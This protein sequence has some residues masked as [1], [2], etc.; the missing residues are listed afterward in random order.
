MARTE[1]RKRRPAVMARWIGEV[2]DT[3]VCGGSYL[4]LER[5][6]FFEPGLELRAIPSVVRVGLFGLARQLKIA[7]RSFQSKQVSKDDSTNAFWS[8]SNTKSVL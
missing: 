3:P 2:S 1:R 7:L 6:L 8:H 5:R 4:Q